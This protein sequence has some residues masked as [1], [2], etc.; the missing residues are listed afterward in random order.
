MIDLSDG[1]P[2]V[3]APEPRNFEEFWAFYLSQHMHPTTRL[4]HAVGTAAAFATGITGLIRRRPATV[5]AAPLLAYGP[6]FASHFIWE[7]NR[8]ATLGGHVLWSVGG[9]LR[10]LARVVSGRVG[11]D[12]EAIRQSLGMLPGQVTLGD[13]ERDRRERGPSVELTGSAAVEAQSL[14][15]TAA[16]PVDG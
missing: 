10:M 11:Q 12:V 9:D 8:P 1:V 3:T 5:A 16:D 4:V 13:W 7:K 14:A 6:A 2:G 15:Q